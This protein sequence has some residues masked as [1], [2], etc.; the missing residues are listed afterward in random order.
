MSS[1]LLVHTCCGPCATWSMQVVS[2]D[3]FAPAMFYSN[4]NIQPHEEYLKRLTSAKTVARHNGV[5]LVEDEY[6]PDL[7]GAKISGFEDEP[8]GGRRCARC[9]EFSLSRTASHARENDF[10]CFT[11]TL[12]VSRHKNSALIFEIGEAVAS[13]YGIEFLKTDF[14]KNAGYEKSIEISKKMGLFRQSYCGCKYSL[15]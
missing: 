2:E 6:Q 11:T 5:L 12:T 1:K 9:F 15:R 14:K 3:G 10:E 8:E 7:W 4:S 13:E